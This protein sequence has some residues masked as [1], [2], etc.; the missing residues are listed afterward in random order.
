MGA[1]VSLAGEV[2]SDT[3]EVDRS[4]SGTKAKAVIA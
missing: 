2:L 1:L 3:L 4:T